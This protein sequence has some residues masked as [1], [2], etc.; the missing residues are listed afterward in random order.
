[1]RN[2]G[3]LVGLVLVAGG[4][5]A[6]FADR[7]T[8][9]AP[10][11]VSTSSPVPPAAARTSVSRALGPRSMVLSRNGRGQFNVDG[12]I[13]GRR[14]EFV[15]DT[16][17]SVVALTMRD[18]SRVGLHPVHRDFT[19]EVHTANGVVRAAPARLQSLEIGDL[20]VYDVSALVLPEDALRENLLGMSFLSKLQRVEMS[21]GRLVLE[22]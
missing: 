16:G 6:K 20:V 12:R 22:Q 1:M 14:M 19:V 18:A 2:I 8:P 15:V 17:A 21:A 3:I 13:D 5:I 7:A 4:T 9:A 10:S 11:A